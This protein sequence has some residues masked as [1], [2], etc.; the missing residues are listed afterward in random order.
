M[1]NLPRWEQRFENFQK[2]LN[3]LDEAVSLSES[4]Q[5]SELEV[6]GLIQRFEYTYELAWK[7]LQD[8]I[9]HQG[10]NDIKGP[11]PVLG[12]AFEMGL[13]QNA[14]GWKRLNRSREL[15]SHTYDNETAEIIARSICNEYLDLFLFL[16]KRLISYKNGGGKSIFN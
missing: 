16:R 13:I 6:E 8:F 2:A 10:Y 11:G 3:K 9:K 5:L 7:T 15:S 4:N 12:Q 14:E 1:D